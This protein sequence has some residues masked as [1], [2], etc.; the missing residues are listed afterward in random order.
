MENHIWVEKDSELNKVTYTFTYRKSLQNPINL[1]RE[2]LKK[3][4]KR[5]IHDII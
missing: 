2:H 5:N 3:S 1:Q 4:T